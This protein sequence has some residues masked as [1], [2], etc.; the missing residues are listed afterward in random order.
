MVA[1]KW[2]VCLLYNKPSQK[3]FQ[4]L[5]YFSIGMSAPFKVAFFLL[6]VFT[7]YVSYVHA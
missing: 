4:G 6:I 5:E 7:I 1:L 3:V 2:I